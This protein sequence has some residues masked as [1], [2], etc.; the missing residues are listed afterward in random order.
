MG[1]TPRLHGEFDNKSHLTVAG[2][3]LTSFRSI[4]GK[5]RG[6]NHRPFVQRGTLGPRD[7]NSRPVPDMRKHHDAGSTPRPLHFCSLISNISSCLKI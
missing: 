6:N 7:G 2:P 1:T 5:Y 4:S 3:S